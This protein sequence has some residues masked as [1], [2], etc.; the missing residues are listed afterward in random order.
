MS[1]K[2][3]AGSFVIGASL[4]GGLASRQSLPPELLAKLCQLKPPEILANERALPYRFLHWLFLGRRR[5]KLC[6]NDYQRQ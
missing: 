2:M 5:S 1:G 3:P 6:P 4:V